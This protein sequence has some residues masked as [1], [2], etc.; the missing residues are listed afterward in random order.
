[1]SERHQLTA[2]DIDRALT[3]KHL[4]G[5]RIVHFVFVGVLL[6]FFAAWGMVRYATLAAGLFA[7]SQATSAESATP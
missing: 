4:L 2:A 7:R 3:G 5:M 6:T 1:M